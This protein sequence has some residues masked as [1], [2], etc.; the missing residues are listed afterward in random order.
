MFFLRKYKFSFNNRI[1]SF[2]KAFGYLFKISI[3][4]A[5][6]SSFATIVEYSNKD[7]IK[8]TKAYS[9]ETQKEQAI[10]INGSISASDQKIIESMAS[11][12]SNPY[13]LSVESLFSLLILGT[14]LS[15]IVAAIYKTKPI[16]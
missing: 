10:S 8:K 5:L 14:I 12:Q 13:V 4:F 15:L 16:E 7:M 2:G 6:F 3:L 1:I 11:F 9:I